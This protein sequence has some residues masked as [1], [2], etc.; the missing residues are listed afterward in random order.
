MKDLEALATDVRGRII[1]EG[2]PIGFL[3]RVMRGETVDGEVPSLKMRVD[4]SL[5]LMGKLVPDL[6]ALDTSATAK[7]D[8]KNE[9][10][11][12]GRLLGKLDRFAQPSGTNPYSQ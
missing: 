5:K 4:V 10:D 8:D 3:L 6:R 7:A 2:D 12:L 11:A 1:E 9:S